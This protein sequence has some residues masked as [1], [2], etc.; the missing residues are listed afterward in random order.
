M[1]FTFPGGDGNEPYFASSRGNI[2]FMKLGSQVAL[3]QVMASFG[4]TPP[5]LTVGFPVD[6]T[7]IMVQIYLEG[8]TPTREDDHEVLE[9][10]LPSGKSF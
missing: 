8:R 5:A 7:S 6:G 4:L 9:Y 2:Y 3:Y 10:H 1:E